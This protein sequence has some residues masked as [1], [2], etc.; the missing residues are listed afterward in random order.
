MTR[1]LSA[2]LVV[3]G[4]TIGELSR[5]LKSFL[6]CRSDGLQWSLQMDNK[7]LLA[8]APSGQENHGDQLCDRHNRFVFRAKLTAIIIYS[9]VQIRHHFAAAQKGPEIP[10]DGPF[11]SRK[12]P[13]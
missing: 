11:P 2:G 3:E 10:G 9:R 6:G 13:G 4:H 12:I 7:V 1:K 8:G 5:L